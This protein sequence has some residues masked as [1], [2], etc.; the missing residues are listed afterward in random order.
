M[1]RLIGIRVKL[2]ARVAAPILVAWSLSACSS[3]PDWV[4]PTTWVGGDSQAT[5]DSGST[6]SADAAQTP[7]IAA[8]PDKPAPPSTAD[9]QK[10]VAD[11][12][13]A[14]RAQ[15]HYSADALRGGTE[16]AAPP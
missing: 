1:P 11:S 14:D 13:E 4:D 6:A 8:I 3:I 12:L 15:A 9:E 16:A 5:S 2:C 7:D 10:N